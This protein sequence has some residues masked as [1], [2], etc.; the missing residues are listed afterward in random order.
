MSQQLYKDFNEIVHEIL[1]E[2]R[3][4]GWCDKVFMT[5]DTLILHIWE[6]HSPPSEQPEL[7]IKLQLQRINQPE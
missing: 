5:N 6:R 2:N 4:C 1:M 3:K 7:M